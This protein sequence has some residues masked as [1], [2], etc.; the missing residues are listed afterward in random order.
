MSHFQVPRQTL[1]N[2]INGRP[3]RRTAHEAQQLLSSPQEKVLHD[4]I[5]YQALIAKPLDR[6]GIESLAFEMCGKLPS[7]K[8]IKGYER[9]NN[10]HAS[11]P[12]GLDPKQAQNFN[13]TNVQHFYRLLGGIYET[14]TTIPPQHIWNMDEKGLQLRG[15][16]KRSSKFYHTEA[17]KKSSF[18]QIH[19]DSLELVTVIECISPSG[20]SVPPMFVL[21]KGSI[22]NLDDSEMDA[23]ISGIITSQNG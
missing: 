2:R 13:P 7:K 5:E 20:L 12:A 8:W 23:P 21:V 17:I 9:R 1:N 18:Y 3:H 6:R 15:G 22:P 16:Q 11:K 10:V 19:A 14:H 4:W